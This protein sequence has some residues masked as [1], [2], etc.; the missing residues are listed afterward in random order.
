MKANSSILRYLVICQLLIGSGGAWAQVADPTK[1]LI[2]TWEGPLALYG[3]ENWRTVIIK[4]V[5][6]KEGGGWVAEGTYGITGKRLGRTTYDVSLQD[7]EIV[8]TFVTG[9]KAPAH[10]KL[11][12]DSKLE[13]KVNVGGNDNRNLKLEKVE[14]KKEEAK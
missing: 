10:L 4:S 6:A 13:G 12:G 11:V 14:P 9:A 1:A 2:G 8:L 7:G 5:K 3:G